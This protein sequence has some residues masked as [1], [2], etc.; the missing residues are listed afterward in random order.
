M[1]CRSWQPISSKANQNLDWVRGL[2]IKGS[3]LLALLVVELNL[4]ARR[5]LLSR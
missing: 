1:H 3:A 4:P 2:H 5:Q